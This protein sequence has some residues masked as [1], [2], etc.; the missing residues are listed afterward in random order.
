MSLLLE[1]VYFGV[2][3]LFISSNQILNFNQL[4]P[5]LYHDDLPL[6]WEAKVMLRSWKKHL[7]VSWDLGKGGKLWNR[8]KFQLDSLKK[9]A[10]REWARKN[11]ELLSWRLKPSLKTIKSP[12]G[13]KYFPLNLTAFCEQRKK[14]KI[15]RPTSNQ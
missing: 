12:I 1:V 3:C 4:Y 8:L 5:L 13:L 6:G 10:Q 2:I 7:A 11:I 15:S 9:C 14:K